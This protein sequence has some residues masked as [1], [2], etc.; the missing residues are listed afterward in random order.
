MYS[1]KD[2]G[3]VN[4]KGMYEKA[5]DGKYA[6][7]GYNFN[8]MEQLQA[9]I[10]ACMETNSPVILQISSGARKYANQILLRHLAAG[11]RLLFPAWLV[12]WLRVRHWKKR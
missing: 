7:P 4:T 2:L 1:Y 9:I 3:L 10:T 11:Q 8:N 5:V 12:R 6:I